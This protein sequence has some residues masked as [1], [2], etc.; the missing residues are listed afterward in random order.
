MEY[1]RNNLQSYY[2]NYC[3]CIESILEELP[4]PISIVGNDERFAFVN[5]AYEDLFQIKR[6]MLLG[7]HYS[8][9][10]N[11]NEKSIHRVVL[12]QKHA[13]SAT[14]IMGS[15]GSL[16]EVE[17]VPLFIA[18]ELI[19]S[20]AIIHEFGNIEK[21][22]NALEKFRSTL[23]EIKCEHA[24]Y[25]FEDIL[26]SS[27][28]I[29]K[30][31]NT[32]KQ[33]AA[34]NVT[35][36]L[37]GE[38]GTGKELFAHAIQQASDRSNKKFLRVNCSNIPETLLESVL[39]GYSEN[40]FTGAKPGGE[41]GLFET[42]DGGTVFLDEIGDL[43]LALQGKLLRVL[44]EKEITRVGAVDAIPVNVR[45]IAATNVDLEKKI[46]THLFR[47]DLYYRINIF[48]ILIPSLRIRKEDIYILAQH[49]L[50]NSA[51]EYGRS[52]VN[53]DYDC[54]QLLTKYD[55]PGNVRE[56]NN[57]IAR[58]VIN[59][60]SD[61]ESLHTENVQFITATAFSSAECKRT[62][63][64]DSSYQVMFESWER[65]MIKSMYEEENHNKTEMAKRLD[66]SIRSVYGK[67]K[68]Y[69]LE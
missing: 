43:S 47:D 8:C 29:S 31:I 16:V 6:E 42:A 18:G 9:H 19:C 25:S 46:A 26:G 63:P 24:K 23:N 12:Q 68:K 35:V 36:L 5:K 52:V 30:A 37:R 69:H 64:H 66:I 21:T 15:K 58:A 14:K 56:L 48:P 60:P 38:S 22:M 65:E 39:F 40:S 4:I 41:K 13:Y 59:M 1:H 28:A 62:I 10:V 54:M 49:F 2:Q 57:T 27:D 20:I 7:K 44:Q 67:L 11:A 3:V 34:T 53:I 55:W 50:L 33:A 17:G 32:A 51:H 45:I 61:Q